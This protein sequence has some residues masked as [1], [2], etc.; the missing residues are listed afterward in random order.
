MLR[1]ALALLLL[2][3]L[4]ACGGGGAGYSPASSPSPTPSPSGDLKVCADTINQY[5]AS[6]GRPALSRS[7]ALENYAAAAAQHD[8]TSHVGHRYFSST[9]GG[10]VASAEN[11]LP[12]WSLLQFHTVN[13][14]ITTGLNFMWQEGPGGGHY[15]NMVGSFSQVGCGVFVNGDE[16]TV[17]Q[18]FR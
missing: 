6:V 16:V 17:V 9:N 11:E 12:W 2:S 18:A 5:R 10:G 13:G 7:A 15:Q 8:G 14:V 4:S 3:G 1:R